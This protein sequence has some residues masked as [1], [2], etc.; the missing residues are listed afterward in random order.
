MKEFTTFSNLLRVLKWHVKVTLRKNPAYLF[1]QGFLYGRVLKGKLY[2]RSQ[3]ILTNI[4]SL[5]N[6]DKIPAKPSYSNIF[7]DSFSIQTRVNRTQKLSIYAFEVSTISALCQ[8]SERVLTWWLTLF[9]A[10]CPSLEI[11]YISNW[12]EQ[13]PWQIKQPSS[14]IHYKR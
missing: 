8:S 9:S 4:G 3:D 14:H 6:T 10:Y 5:R 2:G 13:L 11:V 7:K 12:S 1:K